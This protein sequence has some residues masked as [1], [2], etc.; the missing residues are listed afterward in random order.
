MWFWLIVGVI[1]L[2]DKKNAPTVN[3]PAGGFN[4]AELNATAAA[5]GVPPIHL[6]LAI[7]MCSERGRSLS[8][9]YGYEPELQ[10]IGHSIYNRLK[11]PQTFGN[12]P[13]AVVMQGKKTG[14][15]NEPG[16]QFATSVVPTG[17][18]L[19]ALLTIAD[20]VALDQRRG[21]TRQNVT[22]Y[23]HLQ[24]EEKAK[25]DATWL[26]RGYVF[27]QPHGTREGDATFFA[28]GP[29]RARVMK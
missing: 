9:A 25:V 11:Y 29:Y 23:H 20:G 10:A 22:N 7:V 16:G 8:W 28:P 4:E 14:R 15:T 3:L 12:T 18:L 24:G 5:L 13:W 6:L 21:E 17:E 27:V 26:A 2:N 1:L 19:G